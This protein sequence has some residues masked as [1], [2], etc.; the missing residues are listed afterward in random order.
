MAF[1]I[2]G[3]F[4]TFVPGSEAGWFALTSLLAIPGLF[5]TTK[6]DRL[7]VLVLITFWIWL[8]IAGYFRGREYKQWLQEHPITIEE[9]INT[10]E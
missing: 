2:M 5:I 4:T 7:V 3:H 8:A 1:G 10:I 6:I 9:Q